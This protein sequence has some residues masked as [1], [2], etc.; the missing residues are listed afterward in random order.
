MAADVEN[1]NGVELELLNSGRWFVRARGEVRSTDAFRDLLQVR[2]VGDVRFSVSPRFWM[3]SLFHVVEGKNRIGWEGSNRIMGGFELPFRGERRTF[4]ARTLVERSW[5]PRGLMYHRY[6]QRLALRWTR[7]ALK[8]QLQAEVMA[9][10]RGWAAGRPSFSVLVPV[11][12]HVELDM[13]YHF[14]FRPGRLGGNR[15]M[16]YTY[17]RILRQAR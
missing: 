13:G 15:Q 8:P 9:D 6:R 16:V 4:T 12:K 1:W 3:V 7:V 14:E 17:L 2:G 5:I 11:A 10:S